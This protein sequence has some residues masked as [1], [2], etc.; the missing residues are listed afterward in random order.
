LA[1]G[2]FR[3]RVVPALG[4]FVLSRIA[5]T[6]HSGERWFSRRGQLQRCIRETAAAATPQGAGRS[7]WTAR[8]ASTPRWRGVHFGHRGR[9]AEMRYL[10]AVRNRFGHAFAGPCRATC[11]PDRA[12]STLNRAN[13][14]GFGH[15][16]L[17]A[18][19]VAFCLQKP[20][21]GADF[22]PPRPRRRRRSR[23]QLSVKVGWSIR[24]ERVLEQEF[25]VL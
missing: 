10:Q 5:P 6:I 19:D 2:A 1:T 24:I 7:S 23:R 20:A 4:E 13:P 11:G 17:K 22:E 21:T 16:P 12:S 18:R 3:R 15:P 25:E 14:V 8:L 9:N